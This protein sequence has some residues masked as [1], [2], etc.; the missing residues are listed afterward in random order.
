VGEFERRGERF[1]LNR[2]QLSLH[3]AEKTAELINEVLK[4]TRF[5]LLTVFGGDTLAATVRVMGW[6]GLL[7]GR[8]ILPGV[9]LSEAV[10]GV[11]KMCL[12]TKA[13]G[14]GPEDVLRQIK[15]QLRSNQ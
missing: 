10:G 1:G 11:K 12:I 7:P 13:G 3:I 9:I 4:Q 15:D 8:E 2:R 5:G 14:F 6:R